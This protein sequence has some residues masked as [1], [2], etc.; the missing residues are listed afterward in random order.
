MNADQR[1]GHEVPGASLI[2]KI[3]HFH[4]FSLHRGVSSIKKF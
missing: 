4:V 3:D 1:R 2:I